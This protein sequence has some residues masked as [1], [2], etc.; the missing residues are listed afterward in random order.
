MTPQE[1]GTPAPLSF[2]MPIE[3]SAA[4]AQLMLKHFTDWEVGVGD[5]A[6]LDNGGNA[7]QTPDG[8]YNA[9]A[10]ERSQRDLV[11]KK[12]LW[13]KCDP[14]FPI[15]QGGAIV[16]KATFQDRE[17]NH[18]ILERGLRATDPATGKQVMFVRL[19]GDAGTKR[20]GLWY[21]EIE[22]VL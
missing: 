15:F 16:G 18:D 12:K 1:G 5:G 13:R 8:R 10:Y 2:P 9:V 22:W 7:T 4:V 17:A 19:P 11:G 21:C 6:M 3:A 20:G 14:G